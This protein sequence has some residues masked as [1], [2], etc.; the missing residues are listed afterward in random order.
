MM[1]TPVPT[2]TGLIR[3][4]TRGFIG[5]CPHCGEGKLFGRFLKVRRIARPAVWSCTTT[6][7]TTCR[8]T[9]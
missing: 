2:R 5:R 1:E 8:P 7:P 9:W 4:M 3:S 6:A